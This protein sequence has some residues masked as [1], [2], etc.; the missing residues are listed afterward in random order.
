MAI[1]V[2]FL[3]IFRLPSCEEPARRG[4]GEMPKAWGGCSLVTRIL[5]TC[6]DQRTTTRSLRSPPSFAGG[7]LSSRDN[8]EKS[9]YHIFIFIK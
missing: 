7:Q 9:G 4:G 5:I 2:R 3:A 8:L 6:E 1:Y